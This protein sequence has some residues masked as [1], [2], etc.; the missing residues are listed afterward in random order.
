MRKLKQ[1]QII[2]LTNDR[3]GFEPIKSNIRVPNLSHHTHLSSMVC[4]RKANQAKTE[5]SEMAKRKTQ[6]HSRLGSWT[7][8]QSKAWEGS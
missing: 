3:L 8:E 7:P 1:R 4:L 2:Q 6:G 5:A